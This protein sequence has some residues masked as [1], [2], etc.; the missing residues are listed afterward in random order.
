MR[1]SDDQTVQGLLKLLPEAHPSF[2]IFTNEGGQFV[3][4][5]G[6]TGDDRAYTIS[7]YSKLYDGDAVYRIR[8]TDN[9]RTLIVGKRLTINV[10]VQPLIAE[11]F[12]NDPVLTGQGFLSR[13][14]FCAPASLA[15]TRLFKEADPTNEKILHSYHQRIT[16]LL[17]VPFRLRPGT[18]NI[19]DPLTIKM[20]DEARARWIAFHDSNETRLLADEAN[21]LMKAFANKLPEQAARAANLALA[22]LKPPVQDAEQLGFNWP[23]I[24]DADMAGGIEL[25]RYWL[26]EMLRIVELG[27]PD[28][29]LEAAEALLAWLRTRAEKTPSEPQAHRF[30]IQEVYQRGPRRFRKRWE[31]QRAI[32]ILVTEG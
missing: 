27:S 30:C 31:A 8:S 2:G 21:P 11:P 32:W 12:I 24:T 4:G 28:P 18:R 26:K 10:M 29:Q 16:E 13:F 23:Q 17:R 5:Y 1:T 15:G 22:R 3:G 7:T 14:L 25:A 19:L 9:E 20:T 6:L